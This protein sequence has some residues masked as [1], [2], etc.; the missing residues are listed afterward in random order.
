MGFFA[1][2]RR[3]NVIRVALGYVVA[4]WLLVQ[5]VEI[6]ADAFGAPDWVLKLLIT[7]LAIGLVPTLV[8]AWV[9]EL[10]PDG[11]RR[12]SDIPPSES[13]TAHT[14]KK[15]DLAV[16]GLL[17]AAMGLFAIVHLGGVGRKSEPETAAVETPAPGGDEVTAPAAGDAPQ[18]SI[19]VLPFVNMSAD[20]ENEY[21]ADGLSEELL[22]VLAQIKGLKVAGRTSSFHFK[23]R[24]EDLRQIGETLGVANILEG[25]VR[26]QGD[27]VRI[28]AQLVQASDGF[29]LWSETY[30]RNLDDI[31]AIQDEI[32][33]AV[34]GALRVTLLGES[35][36]PTSATQAINPEVYSRFIAARARIATRDGGKVLEALEML[37]QVTAEAPEYAP[38]HA[39]RGIAAILA[40]SN[41]STLSAEEALGL[42]ETS[43]GKALEIAPDDDYALAAQGLLLRAQGRID[44]SAEKLD[45]STQAFRRSIEINPENVD[46][47]Y[48][49]AINL[50]EEESYEEAGRLLDESLAIDPLAR[51][52]RGRLIN[53]YQRLGEFDRAADVARKSINIAADVWFFHSWPA[54]GE[55][56]RGRPE[57]GLLWLKTADD[58]S[59]VT[60]PQFAQ[61]RLMLYRH[62]EDSAGQT[63]AR[64]DL[65]R[66]G[67]PFSDT[68][69]LDRSLEGSDYA[70]ALSMLE[71]LAR[72]DGVADWGAD[73]FI[74]SIQSGDCERAADVEG[75]DRLVSRWTVDDPLVGPL[76]E[77]ES[78]WLA[79]CM[80]Q[81]GEDAQA[82]KLLRA[83]LDFYRPRSGRF[84][85][86]DLRLRR[87]AALALLGQSGRALEEF[88]DYY[89]AGF[90]LATDA[91]VRWPLDQDVRFASLHK[92]PEFKRI[93]AA[94]RAR[95]AERVMAFESGALTLESPL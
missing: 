24:N 5:V 92:D 31:F 63:A 49:L 9:Y 15:L 60:Q 18:H 22:N 21:F 43:V 16:I 29:H 20:P 75:I 25:S 87:V 65:V 40:W 33:E 34:A 54:I 2:L 79:Y 58:G 78:T 10:T 41:D 17:I 59:P 69:E 50:I 52:A 32:S 37:R 88:R 44:Y 73:I 28:T 51:V 82:G 8:F 67:P 94:I 80:L 57:R 68:A 72:R 64:E 13:N 86:A 76:D 30:D 83:A 36:A 38:A 7:L 26:R 1:E 77:Y 85:R 56:E 84:D 47:F 23:G 6:A 62:L 74:I 3:R 61:M 95:N 11:I 14:A 93:M 90:G 12:E 42:A 53:A 70:G 91:F 46:A 4:G 45:R 35:R 19:A 89:E 27:R 71:A 55:T 81:A 66:L 39:W 48:W